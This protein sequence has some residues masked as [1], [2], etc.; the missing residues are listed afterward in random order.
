VLSEVEE[1]NELPSLSADMLAMPSCVTP[2]GLGMFGQ[3]NPKQ[4]PVQLP[5]GD[6]PGMLTNSVNRLLHIS[7]C[8]VPASKLFSEQSKNV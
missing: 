1:C 4:T 6:T 2:H 7:L 8:H 3:V 5:T